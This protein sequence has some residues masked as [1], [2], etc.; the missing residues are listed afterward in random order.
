M[1]IDRFQHGSVLVL[2]P[3]GPITEDEV[4]CL[5]EALED[6]SNSPRVVLCLREA[7]YVDSQGLELLLEMND[8]YA[9]EGRR[10]RLAELEDCSQE[11]LRLTD[12]QDAFEQYATLDDVVRS[13]L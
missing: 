6:A 3:H 10:L 7:P 1:K 11:I 4:A 5:R 8:W 12:Y 9:A 13:L 2:V